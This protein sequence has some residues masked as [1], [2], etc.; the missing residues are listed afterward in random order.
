M[1]PGFYQKG[2]GLKSREKHII[3]PSIGQITP[4]DSLTQLRD[5]LH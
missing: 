4:T 1:K 5:S 2:I 3:V